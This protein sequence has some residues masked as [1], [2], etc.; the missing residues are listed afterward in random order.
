MKNNLAIRLEKVL[1]QDKLVE[2]QRLL[3]ALKADLRDVLRQY[4]ELDG[5]I[6]IEVQED[7]FGYEIILLAK[8]I[9]FKL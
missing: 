9:R 6:N 7:T 3:P 4:C 5:D 1:M 2:P 8:A